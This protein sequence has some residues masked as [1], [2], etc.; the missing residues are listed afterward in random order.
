[1]VV[2]ARLV[3]YCEEYTHSIY[4]NIYIYI[5]IYISYYLVYTYAQTANKVR[6]EVSDRRHVE[7]GI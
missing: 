2:E 1:M 5:Y 4:I 3:I 6:K 7:V